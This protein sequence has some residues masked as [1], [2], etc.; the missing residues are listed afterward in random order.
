LRL[1]HTHRTIHDLGFIHLFDRG[2][3]LIGIGHF[4]ETESTGAAGVP[5]LNHPSRFHIAMC[6]ERRTQIFICGP[7]RE[8]SNIYFH[9]TYNS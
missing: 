3:R 6:S 4:N 9:D 1:I 2:V 7:E 8:I 5:V